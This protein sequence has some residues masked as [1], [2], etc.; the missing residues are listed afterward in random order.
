MCCCFASCSF[1]AVGSSF[2]DFGLYIEP[3][4]VERLLHYPSALELSRLVA[5]SAQCGELVG[6]VG[7]Q[8]QPGGVDVLDLPLELSFFF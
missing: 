6:G 5:P 3:A 8:L 1:F 7:I 2:V 4:L